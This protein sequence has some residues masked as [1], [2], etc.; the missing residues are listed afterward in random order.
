MGEEVGDE[1]SPVVDEA[2]LESPELPESVTSDSASSETVTEGK[3]L[4]RG[5]F[6]GCDVEGGSFKLARARSSVDLRAIR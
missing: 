2:S 6:S 3:P 5:A 4:D 1:T